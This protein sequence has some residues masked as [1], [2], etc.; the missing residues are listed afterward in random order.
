MLAD[1]TVRPDDRRAR[2]RTHRYGRSRRSAHVTR[3]AAVALRPRP[4]RAQVAGRP[5]VPSGPCIIHPAS[6]ASTRC[7]PGAP[8][9][10]RIGARD[11]LAQRRH[12]PPGKHQPGDRV[13]DPTPVLGRPAVPSGPSVAPAAIH[14]APG[15]PPV[16][17]GAPTGSARG[18]RGAATRGISQVPPRH[19]ARPWMGGGQQSREGPPHAVRA[20]CE[21]R[22]PR[23]STAAPACEP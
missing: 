13:A 5:A 18:R 11:P 19:A 22:L 4:G 20:R 21:P 2:T 16:P 8:G 6:I 1:R 15:H 9:A 12:S 23:G 3:R 17:L 7:A 10:L 14:G